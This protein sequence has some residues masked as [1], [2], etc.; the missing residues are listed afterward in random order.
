MADLARLEHAG[1]EGDVGGLLDVG[2]DVEEAGGEGEEGFVGAEAVDGAVEGGGEVFAAEFA[3]PGILRGGVFAG[4][5]GEEAFFAEG[6]DHG[7]GV[8]VVE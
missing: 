3:V 1:G 5:E 6:H 4:V 7:V 2:A 8:G